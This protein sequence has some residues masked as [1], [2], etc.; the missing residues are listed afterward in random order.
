[1][2]EPFPDFTPTERIGNPRCGSKPATDAPACHAPATWHVLW[3]A[4][5][6]APL[7]L[8]CDE[9][10]AQTRQGLVYTDRHP[11]AVICDMPGTGWLMSTPSRCVLTTTTELNAQAEAATR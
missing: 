5:P 3:T 1:M 6:P 4:T 11:A 10:M 2:T 8:L 9:H 7:S